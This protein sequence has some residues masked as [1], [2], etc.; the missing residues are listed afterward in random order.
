MNKVLSVIIG[1]ALGDALG[2]PV[3][4]YLYKCIAHI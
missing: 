3:E 2:S 4:F 1:H